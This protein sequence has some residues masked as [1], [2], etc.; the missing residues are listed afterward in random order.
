MERTAQIR[1]RTWFRRG[2]LALAAVVGCTLCPLHAG[3]V[4]AF[5]GLGVAHRHH[6][7]WHE[8]AILVIS[9]GLVIGIEVIWHRRNQKK[10]C[11]HEHP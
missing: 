11:G 5:L 9:V 6:S 4:L 2:L 8:V 7:S 3:L 10:C 1:K